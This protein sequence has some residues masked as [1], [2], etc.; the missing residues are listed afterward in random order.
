MILQAVD[1]LRTNV[2]SEMRSLRSD[3]NSETLGLRSDMN[4]QFESIEIRFEEVSGQLKE[5]DTSIGIL[6]DWAGGVAAVTKV[7][8]ASGQTSI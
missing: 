6:A 1:V 8:F 5:I 7:P 3:M 4:S 2:N